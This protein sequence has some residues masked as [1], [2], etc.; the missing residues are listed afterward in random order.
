MAQ[1]RA[2]ESEGIRGLLVAMPGSPQPGQLV[3]SLARDAIELEAIAGIPETPPARGLIVAWLP[4]NTP[5]TTLAALV[6]WRRTSATRAHLVGVA[7][8]GVAIDS[9]RAL[10][11]GFDD[12]MAGRSSPREL[13]A[14]VRALLRRQGTPR[15]VTERTR[16]GRLLL[17]SSRRELWIS[18]AAGGDARAPVSLTALEHAAVAAL[19]AAGGRTLSREE[20]LDRVWGSDDLEVGLRAVDN[21]VCRLRRKLRDRSVLVTVRG[22]GFRLSDQ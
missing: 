19:I 3:V 14:R 13:S 8:D 10:A 11:A 6:A 18:A 21:L 20:L 17:D 9:E 7:P 1:A 16:F 2:E 12:F 5:E 4:A 22:I 15:A